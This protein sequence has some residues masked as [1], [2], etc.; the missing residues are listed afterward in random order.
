MPSGADRESMTALIALDERAG[1]IKRDS[2][3]AEKLVPVAAVSNAWLLK[4]LQW[5]GVAVT[6]N[7]RPVS[8][9]PCGI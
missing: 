8:A 6:A 9:D 7:A 5:P 3:E 4:Q 2:K 1:I